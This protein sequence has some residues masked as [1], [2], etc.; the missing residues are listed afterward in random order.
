MLPNEAVSRDVESRERL[1][2]MQSRLDAK[3]SREK[4]DD[5]F[6]ERV[7]SRLSYWNL[8]RNRAEEDQLKRYEDYRH[9]KFL[10]QIKGD[11][12]TNKSIDNLNKSIVL[13][14]PHEQNQED[15]VKSQTQSRSVLSER[16]RLMRINNAK[17][18]GLEEDT[19]KMLKDLGRGEE[20]AEYNPPLIESRDKSNILLSYSHP[21]LHPNLMK[22]KK[23]LEKSNENE[24]TR[25]NTSMTNKT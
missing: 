24:N 20:S 3:K 8:D 5:N 25:P 2:R 13:K 21:D 4:E 23:E 17:I 18:L 9:N 14:D 15:E 22:S 12:H 19:V 10:E 1:T 11:T 6:N 7:K 16:I